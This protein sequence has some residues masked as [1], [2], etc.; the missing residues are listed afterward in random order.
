MRRAGQRDLRQAKQTNAA[1]YVGAGLVDAVAGRVARRLLVLVSR[2]R[3]VERGGEPRRV[4]AAR[5]RHE[6]VMPTRR[7]VAVDGVDLGRERRRQDLRRAGRDEEAQGLERPVVHHRVEDVEVGRGVHHYVR[8]PLPPDL[9]DQDRL[10]VHRLDDLAVV[11]PEAERHHL[12][13]VEAEAVD[14][15]T[16]VAVAVG[17]QPAAR[18]GEDVLADRRREVAVV[19]DAVVRVARQVG[20]AQFGQ[21]RDAGP[22]GVGEL[23]VG[24]RRV[25][26]R[27]D[28]VPVR[29]RRR[30]AVGEYALEGGVLRA[31][32]VPREVQHDPHSAHV[33]G[34]DEIQ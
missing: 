28:A 16:R 5:H 1:L 17:I 20:F 25:V 4:V 26:E 11:G 14:A 6:R 22:A 27:V 10:G 19:G 33:D 9:A 15:V 8:P 23:V 3:V 18:H 30:R 31:G 21:F 34:G 12:R 2:I 32:V 7:H 29:K 13:H 24:R